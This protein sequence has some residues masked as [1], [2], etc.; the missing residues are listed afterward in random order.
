MRVRTVIKLADDDQIREARRER[1]N[2]RQRL[3]YRKNAEK[4]KARMK[5]WRAANRATWEKSN[6]EWRRKNMDKVRFYEHRRFVLNPA[7]R[8]YLATK[9][10]EYR[11]KRK[12]QSTASQS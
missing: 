1:K 4:M 2:F 11:Q 6:A 3:W 9:S 8:E 12:C 10:R 5:K 7:R